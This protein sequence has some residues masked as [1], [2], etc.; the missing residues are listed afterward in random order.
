[1]F[2]LNPI[3]FGEITKRVMT[4]RKQKIA[5]KQKLVLKA[6]NT[7]DESSKSL[8]IL[9]HLDIKTEIRMSKTSQNQSVNHNNYSIFMS[10]KHKKN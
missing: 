5:A 4:I 10:L 2:L 1:M 6:Q 3:F 8:G 7:F 9:L